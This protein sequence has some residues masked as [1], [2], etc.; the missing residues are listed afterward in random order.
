MESIPQGL[1]RCCAGCGDIVAIISGVML[2][3]RS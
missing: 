2:E 1:F 3:G